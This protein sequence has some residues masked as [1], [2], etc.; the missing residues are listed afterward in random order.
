METNE[1]NTDNVITIDP[2]GDRRK[3]L[4]KYAAVISG[5]V[6]GAVLLAKFAGNTDDEPVTDES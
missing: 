1:S 4:I 2:K 5:V 6:I 3:R